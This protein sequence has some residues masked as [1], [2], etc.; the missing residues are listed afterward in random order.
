M[1]EREIESTVAPARN[2]DSTLDCSSNML[3]L[4]LLLLLVCKCCAA[5]IESRLP[6]NCHCHRH[7]HSKDAPCICCPPSPLPPL[8]VPHLACI[9]WQAL[10]VFHFNGACCLQH[11]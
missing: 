10:N 3:P 5:L 4:L 8:A 9:A 6:A 7:S 11:I 2:V 1:S